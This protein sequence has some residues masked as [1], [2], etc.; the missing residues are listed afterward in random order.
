MAYRLRAWALGVVLL[1][2]L[3]SPARAAWTLVS[4]DSPI[5]VVRAT[6]VFALGAGESLRADDLILSPRQ[7]VVQIQDDNS[8]LVALGA[9][10]R[11]MLQADGRIAFLHGWMKIAHACKAASCPQR[12]V[13]TERGALRLSTSTDAAAAIVATP[14]DAGDIAVFSESGVHT[15]ALKPP[16]TIPAGSFAELSGNAP[17]A[18]ILPRPSSAFL[19]AM[20]A[21]FRDALQPL[22]IGTTP[23]SAALKP[24]R[25]A[26]Y[27][28]IAPWLTTTLP[29][30]KRFA[31]RFHA[32]LA[33]SAFRGSIANHLNTLPE[34][35][36][37]LYPPI[38]AAN[39]PVRYP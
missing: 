22:T 6:N 34:W 39:N 17:A 23:P 9:Q 38:R 28:D 33:D 7:G 4:A 26:T 5:T 24:L 37:F 32:R 36:V 27:D 16:Q 11:V 12:I 15:L 14:D 2:T 31:A 3:S 35:R 25:S 19:A 29:E 21:A 18:H 30:R 1:A 8:T 10:S 20:P 13:E